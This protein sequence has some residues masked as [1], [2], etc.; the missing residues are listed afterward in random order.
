MTGYRL[1]LLALA[2]A[3]SPVAAQTAP[4]LVSLEDGRTIAD[5]SQVTVG[6]RGALENATATIAFAGH[7]VAF[8]A[9]TGVI[10]Y[11]SDV[12][13]LIVARGTARVGGKL[14]RAGQVI[15]FGA[16]G[17]KP[18][19][20]RFDARHYVATLPEAARQRAPAVAEALNHVAAS[21]KTA[22]FL[23]LYQRD[24]GRVPARGDAARRQLL[25]APAVQAARFSGEATPA[26]VE[27]DV[28]TMLV[29]A[30]VDRDAAGLAPLIDPLPFGGAGV[31]AA[32]DAAR[33]AY[34]QTVIAAADWP[35]LLDRAVPVRM[36]KPGVWVLRSAAGPT[37]VT[38]RTTR[39]FVFVQSLQPGDSQ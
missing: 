16:Y 35:L 9:F 10:G 11:S 4:A 17:A 39:D 27:Y 13:Y 5:A 30:L 24:G 22:M 29:R 20:S 6:D 21:Q 36:T 38:L 34:A 14:A 1:N 32:G 18:I 37:F 31:D 2:L 25:G 7:D 15:L 8:A 3:A 33:L 12:G 23:G 19:F 28:V 26:Q